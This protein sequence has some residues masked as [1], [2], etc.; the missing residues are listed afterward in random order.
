MNIF[1]NGWFWGF[2]DK[3]N[4]GLYVD[5]FLNLFEKVYG[6]KCYVSRIEDSEI[7]CE[8]DMLINSHSVNKTKHWKHT[9][10]FSGESSLK[11]NKN[12]YTC[13]LWGERNNKNVVNLPLFIAYIYTNNFLNNLQ[14]INNKHNTVPKNDVLVIIS[15]PYGSV[16]NKF[17]EKL[18]KSFKVCYAGRY[19]NNIGGLI[20]H[21]YNSKEFTNIV[22]QFK[23]II[24]M[25]NS[26]EDTYI[27]EKVIHGLLAKTIPVYWGS[28]R[29]Y[30]YFNKE[31]IIY[32]QD[33]NSIDNIIEKMLE[34]KNDNN[35]YLSIVNSNIFSN[36]D[37]KLERT[38]DTVVN[39]IRCLLSNNESSNIT[40]W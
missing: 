1:F 24:T 29:L 31:R 6:E 20:S 37:N 40:L 5:F 38:L 12:D 33:E 7:L 35:K 10:L 2:F 39:D 18:D 17:L 22:S 19:K 27:T 9:Y 3:T 16:R 26:R 21:E 23:F 30:D 25:E 15:N 14:S 13:V 11:C 8:F 34:I 28:K 32:L 4:P 36:K